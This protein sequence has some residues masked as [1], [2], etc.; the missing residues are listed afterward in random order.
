MLELHTTL[1]T[2]DCQ[3]KGALQQLAGT[4]HAW[5]AQVR[6]VSGRAGQ[7][8]DRSVWA[9]RNHLTLACGLQR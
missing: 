9:L 6:I 8:I 3:R 2:G 7:G 4:L 1:E 5:A